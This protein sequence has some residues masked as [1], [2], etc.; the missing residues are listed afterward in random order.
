MILVGKLDVYVK[1]ELYYTNDNK[2]FYFDEKAEK[3]LNKDD[4][5]AWA[6]CANSPWSQAHLKYKTCLN[7]ESAYKEMNVPKD[8]EWK[9]IYSVI[10]YDGIYSE[11]IGRA[12]CRERV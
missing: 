1:D 11:E 12:S 3:K 6:T 10:G 8:K 2:N 7:C 5:E 9:T 4:L